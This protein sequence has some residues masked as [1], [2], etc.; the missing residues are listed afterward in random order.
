MAC[1]FAQFINERYKDFFFFVYSIHT[2]DSNIE[3]IRPRKKKKNAQH[4]DRFH[5]SKNEWTPFF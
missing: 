2:L 5:W 4:A 1:R 3:E